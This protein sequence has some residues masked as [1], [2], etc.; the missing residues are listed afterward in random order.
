MQWPHGRKGYVNLRSELLQRLQ[1]VRNNCKTRNQLI[2]MDVRGLAARGT[3]LRFDLAPVIVEHIAEDHLGV[4][5]TKEL[6]FC[7]PLAPGTA[8]DQGH[9]P[10]QPAHDD[11]LLA[12]ACA[13]TLLS[14]CDG[15]IVVR[16]ETLSTLS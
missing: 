12:R 13:P 1:E 14:A 3:N 9:F 11:L 4:L 15:P 16:S 8:T 5:V 7:G 2:E 10:S 6:C